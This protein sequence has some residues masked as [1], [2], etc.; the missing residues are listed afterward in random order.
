M[1]SRSVTSEH[2]DGCADVLLAQLQ[3]FFACH[4][5]H[6]HSPGVLDAQQL[7]DLLRAVDL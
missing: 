1:R 7:M 2:V 6:S 4:L 3:L 5:F